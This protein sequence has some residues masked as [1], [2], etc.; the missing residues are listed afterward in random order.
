[1]ERIE[2]LKGFLAEDPGDNFSLYALALEYVKLNNVTEAIQLLEKLLEKNP[3]YLA[4]Y[5]QLGK[6]FEMQQQ[7]DRASGVFEKGIE[8]ARRQKNQKTLS[9][10]QS[11]L[12]LLEE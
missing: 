1:M 11:A 12:D 5:Y 10:L 4:A 3:G 8:V 9:E 7:P 6:L 2:L